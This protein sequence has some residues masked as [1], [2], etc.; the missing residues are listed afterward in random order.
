MRLNLLLAA[1]SGLPLVSA[2]AATFS[3]IT[4][5]DSGSGSLRQAIHDANATS[6]GDII[7]SNVTGTIVLASEFSAIVGTHVE[8]SRHSNSVTA[9]VSPEPVPARGRSERGRRSS[10][11][12]CK[13]DFPPQFGRE[14]QR[15]ARGR[16]FFKSIGPSGLV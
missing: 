1:A 13:F 9:A 3:V 5:L 4:A 11:R 8:D 16:E 10:F 2:Q 7:F 12:S 15:C 6:G 14:I